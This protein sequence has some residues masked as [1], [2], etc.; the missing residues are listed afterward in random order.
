MRYD[1]VLQN[2]RS[3]LEKALDS[4][5]HNSE[6]MVDNTLLGV[7][8]KKGIEFLAGDVEPSNTRFKAL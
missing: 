5:S 2:P 1:R 3:P 4:P 7:T 8:H 6:K